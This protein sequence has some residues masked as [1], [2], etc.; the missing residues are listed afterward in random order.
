MRATVPRAMTRTPGQ[1]LRDGHGATN[2]QAMRRILIHL[3]AYCVPLLG[4]T[5]ASAGAT[6]VMCR[7]ASHPRGPP[8]LSPT[9]Q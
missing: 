9:Y 6:P 1:T 4:G 8:Q 2:A 5:D 7:E 3:L